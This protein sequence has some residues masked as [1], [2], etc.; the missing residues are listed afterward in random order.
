MIAERKGDEGFLY[1]IKKHVRFNNSVVNINPFLASS[2]TMH[3]V[4]GLS[5]FN[6]EVTDDSHELAES[7]L[8]DFTMR[9]GLKLIAR[10]GIFRHKFCQMVTILSSK[11]PNIRTLTVDERGAKTS[12]QDQVAPSDTVVLNQ[13]HKFSLQISTKGTIPYYQ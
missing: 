4:V 10:N 9:G 1:I 2:Q 6:I 3:E 12:P 13:L 8:E 11:F 5:D 7:V